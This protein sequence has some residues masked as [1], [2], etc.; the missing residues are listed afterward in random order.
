MCACGGGSGNGGGGGGNAPT[1]SSV[2]VTCSPGNIQTGQTSQCSVA[3]TGTGNFSSAVTWSADSGT[4]TN[5]GLYTAPS[6]IPASGKATI[7]AT[8][9]QDS[10]KSGAATVTVN[11]PPAIT[12][13]S[14]ICTPA[15]ILP[16]QTAT[17]TPTVSGIGSFSSAVTWSVTPSS[18]G[19]ISTGGVFTPAVV[20]IATIAATST[21]DGSKS[22]STTVTV[23]PLP[24]PTT[25]IAVPSILQAG[26]TTQVKVTCF[27]R[28]ANANTQVQLFNLATGTPVL[29]GT[30]GDTG[31]N[32][33]Q[34]AGDQVYTIAT[35]LTAPTASTLPMQVV[36][37]TGT[38][39]NTSANFSVPVVQIPNYATNTDINQAEAQLYSNAI[40]TRSTFSSPDWTKATALQ[41]VGNNLV[42]MFDELEGVVNQNS[43]LQA[44]VK[45]SSAPMRSRLTASRPEGIIQSVLDVL[46]FGLLSPAQ[47]AQACNQL[48][49]SLSG[50]P[51]PSPYPVLSPDD[52]QM[53]Q[54]A[55][56]LTSACA[57]SGS[58]QGLF[59]NSDFLTS[60]ADSYEA[61]L[62]AQ[63]YVATGGPLATPVAGCGGAVSQSLANVAVKSEASQFTELSGESLTQ[64]AGGGQI[65]QQ[66]SDI[67]TD[68]LTGWVTSSGQNTIVIGQASGTETFAAPAGT[69]NLAV[70]AGGSEPNATVTATVYPN[71]VTYFN[72]LP[73]GGIIVFLPPDITNISPTSGPVGTP[74]YITG[75]NFGLPTDQVAFNGS[76]AKILSALNGQIEAVVPAGATSGP[77]T[78]DSGGGVATSSMSFTV[79]PGVYGNPTPTITSLSPVA[80]AVGTQ[81]LTVTVNGTGFLSSSNVTINGNGRVVTFVSATELQVQLTAADLSTPGIYPIIVINP[82]PGGGASAPASFTVNSA[83]STEGEWNWLGGSSTGG[84]TGVYGQVGVPSTSNSP[85]GRDSAVGWTDP[86]G[87]FWL[88]G[89][90]GFDSTGTSGAL[91]DLWE[92]NPSTSA[93]KWIGGANTANP[94]AVYGTKGVSSTSNTPGARLGEASWTD[95]KGDLW[96]FGGYIGT[97]SLNDLWEYVPSTNAWT[98]VS[99]SSGANQP[100]SYGVAGTAA[101]SN[102]PGA[103]GS[104]AS[105]IDGSGDLWLFGGIGFDSQGNN[106]YLNDLWEFNTTSLTWTWIDGANLADQAGVYGT[107]GTPATTNIPPG[108]IS[109]SNWIDKSGNLWL[110][111]GY[112][113]LSSSDYGMFNDLWEFRPSTRTWTWMGGSNSLDYPS[114]YGLT[115]TSSNQNFPGARYAAT[116]WVDNSGNFWLFGGY[117]TEDVGYGGYFNDLWEFM[118]ATES[119]ALMS[120]SPLPG[121]AGS[122]SVEGS[123]SGSNLPGARTNAAGGVDSHGN[124]WLF[125]GI[126]F[127]SAGNVL[128]LNDLWLYESTSSTTINPV[129]AINMLSPNTL[130]AG[131]STYT[132]SI[133]G[134]GFLPSS[135]VTYGGVAH[136]PTYIDSDLITIDLSAADLSTAGTFAVVVSNPGPGG[137]ASSPA[138]FTISPSTSVVT[139]SPVSVSVPVNAVQTFTATAPGGGGVT[140]SIQ[141]GASGGTVSSAGLYTAPSTTG[142]YHV[143]ATSTANSSLSATA[144]VTIVAAPSYSVLNSFP[145]AFEPAGLI[146]GTDDNFY[147]TNEMYAY[148]I[149]S[150]GVIT[151]L[152]QLSTSPSAPISSLIQTTNGNFYGIDSQGNG[153]I[154]EIDSQGN[155][156]V[157]FSFPNISSSTSTG[158]WPWSG[159][160]QASDGNFYGT[161][162]AGGNL[163]CTPYG[164]GMPAYGPFDYNPSS[165]YGCGTVFRMDTTGNVTLLYSFSG[166]TDGN[167]PQAALIQ[168]SD[169]NLYGTTSGGGASG[170]GTIFKLSTSGSFQLL[171][172]FSSSDGDAPVASLIQAADGFLYGTAACVFCSSNGI[173][174]T[175]E[176]FKLDTSG[177]NFSIL[178]TFSGPDGSFPV[179]PLIQA[180]DGNFYGTTW[181]GGDLTCGTYYFNVGSNYPYPSFR[182]CGTVFKM[183]SLGNVTVLHEFEEP[184]TGDGDA[185][186]SGLVQGKDGNLYGTTYYG[187]SSIYFGT[188]FKVG[189]P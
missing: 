39:G 185:P 45:Q 157:P 92:Y 43:T 143:I 174:T 69:Y 1:I 171:H 86:S 134:T 28:G 74:V 147:G 184:Q 164:W 97:S 116:S 181:A 104:S 32:G 149:T 65:A 80:A 96:V 154:F 23:N 47:N 71:G 31:Q 68:I 128:E 120:G 170:Y 98:W 177:N 176:V 52:P 182:G 7:T 188:V 78:V 33:D 131:F 44:A 85:G 118:P 62:W 132:V 142:T 87:N 4:I 124:L 2:T 61:Y 175:G 12:A 83:I 20:G 82:T 36:A 70:S 167:F 9:T 105:W 183:D 137:G 165:G 146:Q 113:Q 90:N 106:G 117:L 159:L 67:P 151:K 54:F 114:T 93:W 55:Q 141:E 172:S 99:G 138:I 27:V 77:I 156:T 107:E 129:P 180:N 35:A 3:V 11:P 37:T 18:I 115:G 50:Y 17:C 173:T 162:Y 63:Q 136:S 30:M 178:H 53:Q 139:I 125:G 122:Y 108:R 81:S 56:D 42:S 88:F 14:V 169:G 153:S 66:V 123:P 79:T 22:G 161:T 75:S 111:G 58:C 5:S 121:Q 94:A 73:L 145:S 126:G 112:E 91:D 163:N 160:M 84:K 150:A 26:Q 187:G 186:Y 24:S 8:S 101:P 109:A 102:V 155:V 189:L 13:V 49:D 34:S 38:N 158:A 60:T 100:G 21:Q 89:G 135:T 168:G 59:I 152:A 144:T 40:Q 95:A 19:T 29:V 48:L 15:S 10:T 133:V 16:N 46:T 41:G 72:S 130:P 25:A 6:S 127:D 76:A 140:W 179:A 103:R 119:W 64:L 57:S 166:Q 110:F 51:P 148:K